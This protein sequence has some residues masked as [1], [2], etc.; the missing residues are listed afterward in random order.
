VDKDTSI[1]APQNLFVQSPVLIELTP[2]V[3]F[4]V[5]VDQIFIIVNRRGKLEGFVGEI[6]TFGA[7]EQIW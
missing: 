2:P 7:G 4:H 3:F 6:N 1:T 5:D